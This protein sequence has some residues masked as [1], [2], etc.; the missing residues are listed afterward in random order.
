MRALMKVKWLVI[1]KSCDTK[2]KKVCLRPENKNA[3][4]FII[5][6]KT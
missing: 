1:T 2:Y 4:N 5:R 3:F 6:L